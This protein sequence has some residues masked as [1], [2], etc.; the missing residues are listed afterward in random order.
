MDRMVL[1]LN[2]H[3]KFHASLTNRLWPISSMQ[4]K[5]LTHSVAFLFG[6]PR[7]R[8]TN[9]AGCNR[10][11]ILAIIVMSGFVRHLFGYSER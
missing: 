8:P 4:L 2:R 3:P 1:L 5:C 10:K 6:K 11:Q 9:K 7:K